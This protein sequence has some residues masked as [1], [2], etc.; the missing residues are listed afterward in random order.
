MNTGRARTVRRLPIRTPPL[1]G[2]SYAS[3]VDRLAADIQARVSAVL[4]AL[5]VVDEEKDSAIG[6]GYGIALDSRRT[7]LMATALDLPLERVRELF[8]SHYDGRA[9]DLTGIDPADRSSAR[10]TAVRE[11]AYF[12]GTHACPECLKETGGAWRLRWKLPWSF[13]CVKHG[14][15]LADHCP[16]CARRIGMARQD[17]S[18]RPR[19]ISRIPKPGHCSNAEAAGVAATGR[20]AVPCG[21][22]LHSIGTD[23]LAGNGRE[24]KAQKAIEAA[25][26]SDAVRILGGDTLTLDYFRELRSLCSFLLSVVEAEDVASIPAPSVRSAVR[27]HVDARDEI[28]AGRLAAG[29]GWRK[30][31]RQRFFTGV[32]DSAALMAGIL[33]TAVEL[34]DEPSPA[35]LSEALGGYLERFRSLRSG[36]RDHLRYF[37][38]SERLDGAINGYLARYQ[39]TTTRLGMRSLKGVRAPPSEYGDLAV[40]NIP[41]LFWREDYERDLQPLLIASDPRYARRVCS[42]WAVK[43]L[44][45]C[46]WED[47]AQRLEL[48][49][50]Q[51]VGLKTRLL[52]NLNQSG[53][54]E[55]F[56][57]KLR[58]VL[59]RVGADP[60]HVDYVERRK[61]LEALT[62]IEWSLWRVMCDRVGMGVGKRGGKN[63]QAA[64][65]L[66]AELTS[67]D[68][69]LS[70]TYAER[71]TANDREYFRRF[72]NRDVSM[73]HAPLMRYA[74]T[75]FESSIY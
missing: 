52:H 16:G 57:T 66:W 35:V 47:A 65:W 28:R 10:R 70:P 11:W 44:T 27:R 21:Y 43:A 55:A 46:S 9:I 40:E 25:L 14:R 20:A 39:K 61:A 41:Q 62:E 67:S 71:D 54:T 12:S 32:P 68:Y 7:E 37:G 24:L 2:E 19:F 72:I 50:K 13:A 51:C 63:R 73:L 38:F 60:D 6:A 23:T 58:A 45:R 30:S 36:T 33:P 31:S 49:A 53:D 74:E 69:L 15:L 17:G 42:M 34:L 1:P 8:L 3:Y 22:P 59:S 75:F 56:D 29:G 48:P 64:A 5:G 18:S 4:Y 26:G